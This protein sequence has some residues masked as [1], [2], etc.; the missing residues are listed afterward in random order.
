MQPGS[1]EIMFILLLAVSARS[2]GV[3]PHLNFGTGAGFFLSA[4]S[5]ARI[6][7]VN[8]S[9]AITLKAGDYSIV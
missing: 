7:V 6:D 2:W 5:A 8:R 9:T 3:W 4:A 1:A